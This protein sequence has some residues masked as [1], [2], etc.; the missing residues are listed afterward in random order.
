MKDMFGNDLDNGFV[1]FL[2]GYG[3]I[4]WIGFAVTRDFMWFASIFE[5]ENS[6]EAGVIAGIVG[7]ISAGAYLYGFFAIIGIFMSILKR[8]KD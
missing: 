7:L 4:L 8:N 2:V 3:I 6:T 5:G 1:L